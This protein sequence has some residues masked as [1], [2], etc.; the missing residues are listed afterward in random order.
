M[1]IPRIQYHHDGH[2]SQPYLAG[3]IQLR[4]SWPYGLSWMFTYNRNT[5]IVPLWF[6]E[7]P[8]IHEERPILSAFFC[9]IHNP[10]PTGMGEIPSYTQ[11]E[12]SGESFH[13]CPHVNVPK[14]KVV[15]LVVILLDYTHT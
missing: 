12:K 2:S 15:N 14:N 10:E 6:S 5:G 3:G 8:Y 7:I 9:L 13:G 11:A 1:I 4:P